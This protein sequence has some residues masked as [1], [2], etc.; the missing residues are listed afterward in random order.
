[1]AGSCL[2]SAC[3]RDETYV[4]ILNNNIDTVRIIGYACRIGN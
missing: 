2:L 1:M 3:S 4:C